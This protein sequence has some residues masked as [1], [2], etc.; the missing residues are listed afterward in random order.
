M[1]FS[2]TSWTQ[3]DMGNSKIV[4]NG[5]RFSLGMMINHCDTE[6]NVDF[7]DGECYS[8]QTLTTQG[9]Y[10]SIETQFAYHELDK[11]LLG[12]GALLN[13][14]KDDLKESFLVMQF[15]KGMFTIE[16]I[17]QQLKID[18][19]IAKKEFDVSLIL[20][21]KDKVTINLLPKK[22]EVIFH[23]AQIDDKVSE[24]LKEVIL[25]YYL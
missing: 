15:S 12:L 18:E 21:N 16:P 3:D 2:P 20:K 17:K 7:G 23:T 19:W 6:P 5:R 10:F 22:L 25:N 4:Y 14:I 1:E 9:V 13:L 8:T 11:M 24:Y